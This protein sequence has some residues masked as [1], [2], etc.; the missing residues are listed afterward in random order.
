[1][2]PQGPLEF[3]YKKKLTHEKFLALVEREL[4]LI[5]EHLSN[6]NASPRLADR[7]ILKFHGNQF[8]PYHIILIVQS[9]IILIRGMQ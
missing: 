7:L 9:G 1:M 4:I 6:R 3:F 5:T 8:C 2:A